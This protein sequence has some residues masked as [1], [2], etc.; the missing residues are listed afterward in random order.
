MSCQE[1]IFQPAEQPY[2]FQWQQ[3]LLFVINQM[4][5]EANKTLH[6]HNSTIDNSSVKSNNF[7]L[8]AQKGL[9]VGYCRRICVQPVACWF[10][11]NAH[12]VPMIPFGCIASLHNR[13]NSADMCTLQILSP[14]FTSLDKSLQMELSTWWNVNIGLVFILF[15]FI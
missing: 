10:W 14:N 4:F 11:I 1:S 5:I 12:Y 7:I 13:I 8:E 9:T 2:H 3:S 6:N 15:L